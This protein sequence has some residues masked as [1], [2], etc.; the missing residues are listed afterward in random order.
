MAVSKF[1]FFYFKSKSYEVLIEQVLSKSR[2]S[3]R[4]SS[5]N[6]RK[7]KFKEA[8]S[9]SS[10]DSDKMAKKKKKKKELLADSNGRS[11]F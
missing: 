4:K 6:R 10:A 3:Y 9:N 8:M 11:K 5:F 7:L 2:S 1:V